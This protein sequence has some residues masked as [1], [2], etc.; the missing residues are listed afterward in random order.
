MVINKLNNQNMAS[1]NK[2]IL[3]GNVGKDPEIKQLDNGYRIAKF[4]LATHETYKNKDG[5]KGEQTEWHNIVVLRDGLAEIAKKF[6]IKGKQVYV[7]GK[8]RTRIWTDK[9]GVKRNLTEIIAENFIMLGNRKSEE[10][11]DNGKNGL[12]HIPETLI[13]VSN[14][15]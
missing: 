9:E 5:E 10:N 14:E 8:I 2:V 6:I 3:I 4:T 7:E 11:A 13:T 12:D 15:Q 1:L